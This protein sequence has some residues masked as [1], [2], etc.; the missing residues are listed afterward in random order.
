MKKIKDRWPADTDLPA[1]NTL[2]LHSR[3]RFNWDLESELFFLD[4]VNESK[5]DA[6]NNFVTNW[7]FSA[8]QKMNEIYEE[9][10]KFY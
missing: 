4:C 2:F 10:S 3:K 1:F 5:L 8:Y 7:I 6:S 9:Y